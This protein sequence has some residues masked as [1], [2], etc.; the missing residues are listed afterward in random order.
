MKLSTRGRY[1]VRAVFDMAY[2]GKGRPAQIRTIAE[3]QEIPLR[4]LE[5]ILNRLRRAGIVHTL[6]GPRG[7]YFLGKSPDQ[8]TVAEVVR[9]TEGPVRLV[10]CKE[11]GRKDVQCHRAPQCVV[12]QVW[13]EAGRRLN[14]YLESVTIEKLCSEAKKME[15]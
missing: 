8:I 15:L 11:T 14:D 6:R 5:Q 12:R 9:A 7:G 4:Y 10:S 2:Y 3:R 13:E 1:G